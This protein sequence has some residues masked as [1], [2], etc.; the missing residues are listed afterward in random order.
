MEHMINW[1]K[2]D[3]TKLK[4]NVN[5]FNK[6]VDK[7]GDVGIKKIAFEEIKDEILT[8]KELNR[9]IEKM[10]RLTENT[11]ETWNETELNRE[12]KLSERRLKRMLKKTDKMSFMGDEQNQYIEGELKNIANLDNLPNSFMK[13]KIER[14]GELAAADYDLKVAKNYQE[15]Y[16]KSI[17][18]YYGGF[19][20][21]DK[22]LAKL[23]GFKNPE[24]FYKTI[25][26][27]IN[28]RDINMI[29]Y[30][31]VSQEFF[32]KILKAWGMSD[33]GEDSEFYS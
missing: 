21:S 27:D 22:L 3:L 26:F 30:G 13:R 18:E 10:Q 6:I 19:K 20:G 9:Q 16:I 29:R 15:W 25:S 14:I 12:I 5:R 17:K 8:R 31:K 7:M 24:K 28:A 4:R 2:S 32:N 33:V 23:E 1:K 11:A